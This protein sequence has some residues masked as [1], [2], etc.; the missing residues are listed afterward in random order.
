MYNKFI[1]KKRGVFSMEKI[2]V[3]TIYDDEDYLRQI[4]KPVELN[5]KELESDLKKLEKYCLENDV[6][7]MASVQIGI[8]KRLVYLKN[9]NLELIR[10][11]Q[12]NTITKEEENYNEARVLIN[13]VIKS[14]EGLT[15]YWENCASCLDNMGLVKRPYKIK[16]EY[17]DRNREKHIDTFIGFEATVLS[18]EMD[19]L[20]GIL[21][22]DIAD[23]VINMPLEERKEFRK[24][25][26]YTIL[27]ETGHFE[28]LIG[29]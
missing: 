7:A 16:V 22:M 25:H 10:K 27:A 26:D 20:D 23:E 1:V 21:H 5:D 6:F 15:T 2:K 11:D 19:H 3:I 14:R 4:S 28:D 29:K 8:P 12:N 17:E 24:T 18:H 9:T 13:P